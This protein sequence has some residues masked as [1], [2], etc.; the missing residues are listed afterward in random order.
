MDSLQ[1]KGFS[2]DGDKERSSLDKWSSLGILEDLTGERGH[3]DL[4]LNAKA[5][6]A[7]AVSS[8][9]RRRHRY[10]IF[11]R[12][13]DE[14]EAA[15]TRHKPDEDDVVLWRYKDDEYKSIFRTD[16]TWDQIRQARSLVPWSRVVW[17][18]FNTPKCAFQVW[19]AILNRL[20]TGDRILSWNVNFH[21]SCV[22]CLHPLES[23]DHLFFDCPY[24]SHVWT[25]LASRLFG[26]KFSCDWETLMDF[27]TH[28]QQNLL[29]SFT[30]KYLFHLTLYQIWGERNGRRHGEPSTT[31][32]Q[33][34][35]RID[36]G[37][38]N[39]FNSIRM[40]GNHKYEDGY[41]LWI[42]SRSVYL[43]PTSA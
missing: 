12:I 20:P 23:R 14:I 38:R 27:L 16:R 25:E 1:S 9:R 18:R 3:L 4:G 31:S 2:A 22:F 13:E 32:T 17:F 28:Q 26:P 36:K 21:T 40:Q 37:M 6:V 34:I 43:D 24:T 42:S 7:T 10:P 33:L 41:Q 11:N 8:H 15:R 39:R 29:I 35:Q 5:T 30:Q 19:I